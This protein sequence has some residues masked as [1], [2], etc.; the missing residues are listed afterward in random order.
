MEGWPGWVGLGGWL[1][2]EIG[3]EQRELIIS[4]CSLQWTIK[5]S[6]CASWHSACIVGHFLASAATQSVCVCYSTVSVHYC[7]SSAAAVHGS[8]QGAS[9]DSDMHVTA[10]ESILVLS[11]ATKDPHRLMARNSSNTRYCKMLFFRCILILRFS[12]VENS[13]HFNLVDFPVK[14]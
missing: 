11:Q 12:Y 1:Y 7:M 8:L 13:L 14:C 6:H 9:I 3:F 4:S 10:L 5:V 2:T